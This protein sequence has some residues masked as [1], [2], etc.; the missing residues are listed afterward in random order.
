MHPPIPLFIMPLFTPSLL[1]VS[2]EIN[3]ILALLASILHI[4]DIQFS[5][6]YETDGVFIVRE[7]VMEIG[8]SLKTLY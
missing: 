7:D 6:D 1:I 3:M 8:K 5:E 4:T 2:Q